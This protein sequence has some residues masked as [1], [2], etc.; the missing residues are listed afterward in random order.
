MKALKQ[1]V[2]LLYSVYLY[3]TYHLL[4]TPLILDL[5]IIG[6]VLV[7]G[8]ILL[9]IY[10]I[11]KEL[12]R[13]FFVYSFL[14]LLADKAIFNLRVC[15]G[16]AYLLSFLLILFFVL[17][18]GKWYGKLS[19][20]PLLLL[21]ISIIGASVL[22]E[23]DDV[24]ALAHFQILWKSAPLYTGT[25]VDYFPH[26]VK[27]LD[28][29]GI[30]E[31]IAI[32]NV[33]HKEKAE[34]QEEEEQGYI[35]E[36]EKLSLYLL[37]WNGEKM[38]RIAP[39]EIGVE[40]LSGLLP[41]DYPGFPYFIL[42]EEKLIPLIQRQALAEG[43]LQFGTT[44]FRAMALNLENLARQLAQTDGLDQK[45]AFEKTAFRDLRLEN[46]RISG[47]VQD[48]FFSTASDASK[49]IG[50]IRLPHDKEG[51]VLLGK[52][53]EILTTGQNKDIQISHPLTKSLVAD[54]STAEVQIADV[55]DDQTD[56][57]IL[58]FPFTSISKTM[59]IKPTEGG[60]YHILWVAK[61][62]SFRIDDIW[63][64]QGKNELLALDK[65]YLGSDPLRYLAGY[66]YQDHLLQRN[67]KIFKSFINVR[68]G[69]VDGDGKEE[70]VANV[71]NQ[72]TLYIL[73]PHQ[74]PIPM[75]LSALTAV[76]FIYG[77]IRSVRHVNQ[78]KRN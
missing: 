60:E 40:D 35:L 11:P 4:I 24:K 21:I 3:F 69:D 57:L 43:A 38:E 19:V 48:T 50:E 34:K 5:S 9:L 55:D 63:Q 42:N 64:Q 74:L 49:I 67:W 61:D 26:T 22:M 53:L 36:P 6:V 54:I 17:M 18:V 33:E 29:D 10:L 70:L 41:N 46:G 25:S 66:H 16:L 8:M 77:L 73:K 7:T 59:M 15:D 23:R 30:D 78:G 56:E 68:S 75:L 13:A 1:S 45:Q 27:D 31:I 2:W 14:F 44:P 58:S 62:K 39:R 28:G 71:Y 52:R 76:L 32:G 37:K 47:V 65:S 12:R 20:V 51:V 72:H